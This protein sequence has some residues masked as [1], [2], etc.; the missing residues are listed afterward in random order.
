VNMYWG[1]AGPVVTP[2]E[3]QTTLVTSSE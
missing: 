1:G 3:P 2:A